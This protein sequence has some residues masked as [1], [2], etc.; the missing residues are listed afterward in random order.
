MKIKVWLVSLVLICLLIGCDKKKEEP[1]SPKIG[2]NATLIDKELE[3]W[4]VELAKEPYIINSK[5]VKNPF[6]APVV[7]KTISYEN[8]L[9]IRLVGIVDKQGKKWALIQDESK[10][11]YLV[12]PGSKIG[13]YRIL[14][15]EKNQVLVEEEITDLYGN[16]KKVQ[17]VLSLIKE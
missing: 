5:E 6:I 17:R 1:I 15:I 7:G 14:K 16:R 10:M 2:V 4:K 8:V 12:K 13:N 9:S 3:T 11:G